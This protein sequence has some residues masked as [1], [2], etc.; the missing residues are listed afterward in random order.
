M[1]LEDLHV[2]KRLAREMLLLVR[3]ELF[4]ALNDE[5]QD[6]PTSVDLIVA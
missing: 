5:T 1:S 3:T 6:L 2:G 4:A